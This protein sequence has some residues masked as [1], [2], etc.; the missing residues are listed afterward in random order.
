M[1]KK[2][3]VKWKQGSMRLIWVFRE[4][5]QSY[6]C[7]FI[8]LSNLNWLYVPEKQ[9]GLSRQRVQNHEKHDPA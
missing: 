2:W 7:G 1:E 6:Q 5:K 8:S 3:K 4:L 9:P